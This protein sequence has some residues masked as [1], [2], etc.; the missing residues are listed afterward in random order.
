MLK[1]QIPVLSLLIGALFVQPALAADTEP[2]NIDE[3]I[4]AKIARAKL[5]HS[6]TEERNSLQRQG[7]NA[8]SPSCGS[9]NVGNVFGD[10]RIGGSKEITVVISGDVINANNKCR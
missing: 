2:S 8:M 1:R 10:K 4:L 3:R 6:I 5:K 9:L 7:S